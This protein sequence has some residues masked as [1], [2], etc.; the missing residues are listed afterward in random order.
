MKNSV[1]TQLKNDL[2]A[3]FPESSDVFCDGKEL[4]ARVGRQTILGSVRN[5]KSVFQYFQCGIWV[6]VANVEELNISKRKGS[7]Q[8]A[9]IFAGLPLVLIITVVIQNISIAT[10]TENFFQ[11]YLFI[12]RIL[13]VVSLPGYALIGF[14]NWLAYQRT[15]NL[16]S[17]MG[18]LFI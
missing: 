10:H 3:Q 5:G 13:M 1:E 11:P 16:R 17:Y 8:Q 2:A 6:D 4:V 18:E 15:S 14:A 9:L 12:V 7:V